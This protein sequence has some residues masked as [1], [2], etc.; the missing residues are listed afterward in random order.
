VP[1]SYGFAGNFLSP[2][3]AGTLQLPSPNSKHNAGQFA[4]T[5]DFIE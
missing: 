2:F 5:I 1:N 4:Q 3:K